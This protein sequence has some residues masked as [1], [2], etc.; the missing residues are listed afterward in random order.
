MLGF[1]KNLSRTLHIQWLRLN[2]YRHRAVVPTTAPLILAPHPD[3]EVF[4][5]GGLITRL[6]SQGI[7]PHVV[8]MSGGGASHSSCCN[9]PEDELKHNRRQLT[10]NA[11]KI[12]KLP[13]SHIHFLDFKDGAISDK[14]ESEVAKLKDLIRAINPSDIFIPHWGEG[15]KDHL[16]VAKIAKELAPT[17]CHIY[18]YCVWMWFYNVWRHLSWTNAHALQLSASEQ[19]TKLKAIEAYISPLAPCGKPWSGVL[20]PLF[21]KAHQH[22]VELYF[23]V[24]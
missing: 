20:P 10:L 19:Q 3:D 14:P 8:I 7:T 1:I 21:V 24:K 12:L 18:E 5:C 6:I 22:E 4:G 23:K 2:A 11:A 13:K 16:A 9:L 17:N 15:W